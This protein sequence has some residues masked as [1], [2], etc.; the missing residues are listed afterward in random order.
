MLA[1]PSL[2]WEVGNA[3]SA[4]LKR[5]RITLAQA[6]QAIAAYQ[7][8]PMRL[9]DVELEEA[10]PISA[11]EGIYAYDAYVISCALKYQ[12]PL[13]SLDRQLMDVARKLGVTI[14]EVDG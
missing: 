9:V 12:A 11:E 2:H 10:L 3:L 8:V 4:M 5:K 14:L 6:W 7:R 1:P 13:I